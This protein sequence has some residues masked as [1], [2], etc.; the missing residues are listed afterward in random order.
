MTIKWLLTCDLV[1]IFLDDLL[2][3]FLESERKFKFWERERVMKE[4]MEAHAAAVN[5]CRNDQQQL[6]TVGGF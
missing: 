3:F 2:E 4:C 1:E 6:T 5:C